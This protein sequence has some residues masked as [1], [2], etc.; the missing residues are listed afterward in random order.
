M[1]SAAFWDVT[2]CNPAKVHRHFGSTSENGVSDDW[3]N[4]CNKFHNPAELLRVIRLNYN[5]RDAINH[6]S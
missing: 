2:K 3:I 1:K 5:T 6:S 4:H